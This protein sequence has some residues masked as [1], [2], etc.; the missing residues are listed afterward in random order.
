[1]ILF[2]FSSRC[3]AFE[4][5]KGKKNKKSVSV[6][7]SLRQS[8]QNWC[9]NWNDLCSFLTLLKL[10]R[11]TSRLSVLRIR[12]RLASRRGEENWSVCLGAPVGFSKTRN[13]MGS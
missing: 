8:K 1:M 12:T 7:T 4:N 13:S 5:E 3:F 10:K 6:Q 2:V 11:K 9:V